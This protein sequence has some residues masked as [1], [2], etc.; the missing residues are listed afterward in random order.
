MLNNVVIS[1]AKIN[2][3][4]GSR[5]SFCFIVTQLILLVAKVRYYSDSLIVSVK[6]KQQEGKFLGSPLS[7][8][9]KED[10][11]VGENAKADK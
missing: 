5:R 10:T 6:N 3:I 8:P 4:R 2:R 9:E 1:T 11:F 7:F